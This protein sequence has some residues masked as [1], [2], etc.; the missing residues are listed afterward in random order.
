MCTLN[1][2][3]R[4]LFSIFALIFIRGIDLTF[5]FFVRSLWI[6]SI[7]VIMALYNESGRVP[8]VSILSTSLR[9]VG[10]RSL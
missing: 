4:I 2:F 5:S 10:I 1:Q 6:L 3:V 8:S 9:R 7:R